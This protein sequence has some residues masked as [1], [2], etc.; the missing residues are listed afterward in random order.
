MTWG[1]FFIYQGFN[2]TAGWMHTSTGADAIDEFAY[3]VIE[4]DDGVYYMYGEEERRDDVTVDRGA[5][6]RWRLDV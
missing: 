2:E 4:R 6:P 1:Q 5:L 3:E